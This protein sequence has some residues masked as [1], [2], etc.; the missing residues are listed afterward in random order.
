MT[1]DWRDQFIR[2]GEVRQRGSRA[3]L[4][5][6]VRAGHLVRVS[7]GVYGRPPHAAL[8]PHEAAER[9]YLDLVKSVQLTASWAPVFSHHSAA[10]LWKLPAIEPW[11]GKVHVAAGR[12]AGGRSTT[13]IV[14]HGTDPGV[15]D[16]IDG[17]LVTSLARTVVDVARHTTFR[18]AVAMADAALHGR[19]SATG[20]VERHPVQKAELLEELRAVGRGRGVSQARAVLDFAD[21][22]S[23]S[24]GESCSRVGFMLLGLPA[25][26]LQEAFHDRLGLI[27]YADFW[28]PQCNLIGEFDGKGKYSDP[29]FL[30]G[31]APEQALADEKWREDRLRA[32]GPRVSRWDWATALSLPRLR[33]HLRDAGLR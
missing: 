32:R 18:E 3:Q 31:R 11:P 23:G 22:R 10:V 9:R 20:R 29:L 21:G 1:E 15:P 4:I 30:R 28:W 8:R 19:T 27:G 17:L 33:A 7:R 6:E 16:T 12:L 14:R 26:V 13:Q 25:P 24:A 2:E 5:R